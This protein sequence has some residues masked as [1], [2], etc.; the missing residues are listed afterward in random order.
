[1]EEIEDDLTLWAAWASEKAGWILK[2][3]PMGFNLLL[4]SGFKIKQQQRNLG[5]VKYTI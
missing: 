3:S 5:E 2:P 1:M 4:L